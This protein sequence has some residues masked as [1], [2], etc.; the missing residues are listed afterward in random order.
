VWYPSR[1]AERAEEPGSPLDV[2]AVVF[3]LDG[4]LVDS[5]DTVLEC[6]RLTVREL[7]GPD[8]DHAEVLASFSIGPAAVMLASL[9]GAPVGGR[10]VAAYEAHLGTHADAILPFSGI[11][12]M[13]TR[14]ANRFPLAVFSAADTAAAELL[15]DATGLRRFLGPVVGADRVERTKPAPDGLLE[16]ARLLRCDAGRLVYVGDGPADV[17]TARACGARSIAA[18]WGRRFETD[19]GGDAVAA[20]PDQVVALLLGTRA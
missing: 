16:T 6:Y 20:T 3:D 19:P 14:L 18:A 12:D 10:A 2:D 5:L 9:I 17:A 13:L 4:T 15:L 1:M 11:V 8:L 7:G